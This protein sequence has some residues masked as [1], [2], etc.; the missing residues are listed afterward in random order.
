MEA[1]EGSASEQ[2]SSSSSASESEQG[3]RD[4]DWVPSREEAS[5]ESEQAAPSA[6]Q[7]QEEKAQPEAPTPAAPPAEP[8]LLEKVKE[9]FKRRG[10]TYQVS[11]G[12]A[13]IAAAGNPSAAVHVGCAGRCCFLPALLSW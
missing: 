2:P 1:E 3:R 5:E 4:N 13:G 10:V 7:E 9:L 12:A 8:D 11:P 6:G